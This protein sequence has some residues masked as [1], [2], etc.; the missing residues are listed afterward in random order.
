[1]KFDTNKPFFNFM[2]TLAEF[3]LLNVIFLI[4][5]IPII[6]IGPSLIALYSVTFK[7]ANKEHCSI[8]KLF[9][10]S[11]K[12]NFF[13]GIKA[14][15]IFTILFAIFIF[16][17]IFWLNLNMTLGFILSSIFL[18]AICL[19]FVS[20]LYTFPLIANFENTFIQTLKNSIFIPLLHIKETFFIVLIQITAFALF[21]LLPETKAF[22]LLLGFAFIALCNSYILNKVF[23]KYKN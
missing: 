2:N 11:F 17:L 19:L 15:L 16:N 12:E 5:C 1:M 13:I 10:K 3:F 18:I 6:T 20:F 23:L 22:M 9:F 14:F 4:F 7:E 21:I 8:I